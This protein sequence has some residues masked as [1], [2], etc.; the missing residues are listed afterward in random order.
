M[1]AG[2]RRPVAGSAAEQATDEEEFQNDVYLP[3]PDESLL[4]SLPGTDT[5]I[6]QADQTREVVEVDSQPEPQQTET[7]DLQIVAGHIRRL[8]LEQHQEV[9][10]LAQEL[11]GVPGMQAL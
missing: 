6:G 4:L 8:A 9:L 5:A 3:P 11:A 7:L 1:D 2:R 10:E